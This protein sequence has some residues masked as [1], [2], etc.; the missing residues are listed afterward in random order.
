M[1][2]LVL[3]NSHTIKFSTFKD[4]LF[5]LAITSLNDKTSSS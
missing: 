1:K 5:D 4:V 3:S 2:R